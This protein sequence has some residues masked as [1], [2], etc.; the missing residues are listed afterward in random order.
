MDIFSRLALHFKAPLAPMSEQ[1]T[2]S[3]CNY[4]LFILD[5]SWAL[6]GFT[7]CKKS[8][9]V[10]NST[11]A[12]GYQ[13]GKFVDHGDLGAMS[14][15]QDLCCQSHECDVAFMAGKRCFSVHCHSQAQCLWM[16]AKDNKYMLQLSY[17]ASAHSIPISGTSTLMTSS[18][19]TNMVQELSKK[20]VLGTHHF[21]FEGVG[22]FP[23]PKKIMQS[24][25]CWEK[26]VQVISSI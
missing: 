5:V 20:V 14:V 26:F 25:N 7:Q 13:S 19:R 24:K 21:F 11:L 16:P 2:V 15:C 12:N 4:I 3:V 9:I 22:Q 17:I 18:R 1:T 23:P 6:P 8:A 10:F